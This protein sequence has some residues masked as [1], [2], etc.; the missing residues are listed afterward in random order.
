MLDALVCNGEVLE[1]VALLRRWQERIPINAV[2]YSTLIK[3]F[4]N[5]GDAKGAVG[6]WNELR[7]KKL[8][9]STAVY[10]GI[11][12]VHAR[13]GSTEEAAAL[14]KEMQSDGLKPDHI[15]RSVVAKGFCVS[16]EID[17]AIEI[18]RD[19]PISEGSNHTIMYN[20]ILDGCVRHN[21]MD[22]ADE[23]LAKVDAFHVTP[24]NFTL[25]II[26]KMW[27][28]RRKISEAFAAV[29]TLPKR[30]GFKANG[31]VKACLFF[32]CLRN[33]ALDSAFEVFSDICANEVRV[34]GKMFSAMINNFARVG[35]VLKAV[36]LVEQAYG[37]SDKRPGLPRGE[38]LDAAC[39]ESLMKSLSRQGELERLG[40]PLVKKMVSAKVPVSHRVLAMSL[41]GG[42]SP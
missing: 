14:L 5:I 25:G 1:G 21:R 9:M 11:I 23:L 13:V 10:N 18:L 22:L 41:H 37:L 28:R 29:A 4:N 2:L 34:D 38:H 17:K 42:D 24:T 8:P 30:Y 7:A 20:T 3:G 35:Q 15:T 40:Q 19:M 33:D 16:G 39:L 6:M 27:G 32:A 36:S 12:D 31:A 26:V